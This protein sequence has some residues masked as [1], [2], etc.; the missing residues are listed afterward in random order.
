MSRYKTQREEQS[1]NKASSTAIT[2]GYHAD[3]SSTKRI[4]RP[5]FGQRTAGTTPERTP[6]AGDSSDVVRRT[7]H[8]GIHTKNR[9]RTSKGSKHSKRSKRST[10]SKSTKLKEKHKFQRIMRNAKRRIKR[11][12]RGLHTPGPCEQQGGHE[13]LFP[14]A[15]NPKEVEPNH[16]HKNIVKQSRTQRKTILRRIT[17]L[18]QSKVKK[19]LKRK[20][21][22]KATPTTHPHRIYHRNT[23]LANREL[24][25]R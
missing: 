6:L 20:Q 3:R 23:E 12:L 11:S 9:L 21:T 7:E 25:G 10:T 14:N 17:N 13:A 18:R 8:H 5:D 16:I 15:T 1:F 2:S 4:S 22:T 24:T 19:A